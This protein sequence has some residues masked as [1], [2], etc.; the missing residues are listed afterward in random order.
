MSKWKTRVAGP[1]SVA[2]T[3]TQPIF[4]DE[5]LFVASKNEQTIFAL[6][7]ETGKILW[8]HTVDG[9]VD[10]PPTYYEG[11]LIFGSRNGCIYSLRASD[12]ALAW[13]YRVAPADEQIVSYNQLESVW[14]AHGSTLVLGD[15]V[16]AAAGRNV[17]LDNGIFL[18]GLEVS[19]GKRLYEAQLKNE[20][21]N[22][23][24]D[25]S[26][27]YDLDGAKLDVLASDGNLIFM[28]RFVFDKT[29]KSLGSNARKKTGIHATA[30]YLDDLAWNRNAWNYEKIHFGFMSGNSAKKNFGAIPRL[31]Q[32]LV[33]DDNLLCGVKYFLIRNAQS[34]VFYPGRRGYLLFV[35]A[36]SATDN[37]KTSREKGN[38]KSGSGI[39][40]KW[41]TMLPVRIRAMTK[42]DQVLFVAGPPDV[43]GEDPLAA[44]EGRGG[45]RLQAY[46]A[47]EGEKLSELELD[48]H[49]VFDGLIAADGKIF[50]STVDGSVVCFGE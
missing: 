17:Y 23:E 21:Q 49:P 3:L 38:K 11:A 15:V 32:L 5:R 7:S 34:T 43:I 20:Q 29:L 31:G 44:F 19:T 30:G 48:S 6:D 10:S 8:R 42:A 14:P 24:T 33:H 47:D 28:Q 1:S 2:C 12:G 4:A 39:G 26:D 41:R 13:R 50:M 16:Y 25:E 37:A 27:A 35:D 22:P 9:R 36:L 45:G 18:V 40:S 46:S